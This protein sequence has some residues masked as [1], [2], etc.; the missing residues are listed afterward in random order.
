VLEAEIHVIDGEDFVIKSLV[1]SLVVVSRQRLALLKSH[2]DEEEF[3]AR[4]V[5][6]AIIEK[7][8][9]G[10]L[11]LESFLVVSVAEF[12]RQST[13]EARGRNQLDLVSPAAKKLTHSNGY[14]R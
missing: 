1:L 5:E 6:S 9:F 11:F 10:G 14:S 13:A 4:F 2:I 12:V 3:S 8:E 7:R